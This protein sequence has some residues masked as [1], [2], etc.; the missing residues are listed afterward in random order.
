MWLFL[1]LEDY[2][3]SCPNSHHIEK[4][5]PY[6]IHEII[7]GFISRRSGPRTHKITAMC[8]NIVFLRY[9][10]LTLVYCL[11][12]TPC[13]II[14]IS[15]KYRNPRTEFYV[16]GMMFVFEIHC[17]ENLYGKKERVQLEIETEWPSYKRKVFRDCLF[18]WIVG[19]GKI[20]STLQCG[21]LPQGAV[22][23]QRTILTLRPRWCDRS[24][25]SMCTTGSAAFLKRCKCRSQRTT[26]GMPLTLHTTR[27]HINESAW[28]L[29]SLYTPTGNKKLAKIMAWERCITSE[30]AEFELSKK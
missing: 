9:S 13:N 25:A 17:R 24:T 16:F 20:R 27:G 12:L 23:L 29:V 21:V 14:L 4:I 26:C 10:G 11:P 19:F 18:Q 2:T 5:D 28:S 7:N 8:L 6:S 1:S 3:T 30:T 15:W 22:S